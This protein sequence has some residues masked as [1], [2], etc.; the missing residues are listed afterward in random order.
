MIV[1]KFKKGRH[2]YCCDHSAR[3]G[4]LDQSDGHR[5]GRLAIVR[6]ESNLEAFVKWCYRGPR[7]E[8]NPSR[9]ETPACS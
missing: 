3:M 2:P 7:K 1:G 5:E 4:P 9:P 6:L 8:A